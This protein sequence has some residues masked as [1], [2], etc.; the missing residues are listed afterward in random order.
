MT[1]R[2]GRDSTGHTSP[3]HP[4]AF[5]GALRALAAMVCLGLAV[6]VATADPGSGTERTPA[7]TAEKLSA[8]RAT[9]PPLDFQNRRA[10]SP[11]VSAYFEY[12][13]LAPPDVEHLFGSF[14]SGAHRLAGHVFLPAAPR[15]TV[16]V[17]HGFFDHTG[18]LGVAIRYLL[19]KG[20]AVAALDLPGHG[21]SS[22]PRAEITDFDE[23]AAAF[24]DFLRLCRANM[25][26]PCHAVA[27]STGAAAVFTHLLTGGEDVPGQVVLVAPLV[28]SAHWDVSTRAARVLSRFFDDIPRVFR[29]NTSD[30]AFAE[31]VRNDPL[32]ARHASLLWVNALVEWNQRVA[33]Y[34][35]SPRPVVIIQGDEDSVVDWEYNM[36]F[37]R[38]KFPN[39]RV[40]II[41][42]GR[43]Q[44]LGEGPD[45]RARVV[46][47]VDQVLSAALPRESQ[48]AAK[49]K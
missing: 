43:H 12:Y 15:G 25:P 24:G 39:A 49:L 9:L 3:A 31:F 36:D 29:D 41:E 16:I 21:L 11:E 45:I 27:H 19:D 32:Q 1:D 33:L 46:G 28:R 10:P 7:L 20:F 44:L 26:P 5:P 22:G 38:G 30:A 14:P 13:G 35:P 23:Y 48:R 42:G 34:P 37:L 2:V 6:S 40:E 17:V 47:I 4:W 18:T 8:L